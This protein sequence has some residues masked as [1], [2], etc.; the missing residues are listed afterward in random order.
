MYYAVY[1]VI[2]ALSV[3]DGIVT[4]SHKGLKAKFGEAYVQSGILPKQ[5]ATTL[6]LLCKLRL[7]ADYD[8]TIAFEVDEAIQLLEPTKDLIAAVR[9]L[10]VLD[11]VRESS[12]KTGGSE[13]AINKTAS[14]FC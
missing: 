1:H 7:Q 5:H 10:I 11:G 8:A 2:S 3:Q 12:D 4:K 6:A 13:V 14:Q 9:N